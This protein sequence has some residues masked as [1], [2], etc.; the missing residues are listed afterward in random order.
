MNKTLVKRVRDELSRHHGNSEPLAS[1]ITK[2]SRRN[3][4]VKRLAVFIPIERDASN[5]AKKLDRKTPPDLLDDIG[6]K[7]NHGSRSPINDDTS[8]LGLQNDSHDQLS[9]VKEWKHLY[10]NEST[11][12]PRPRRKHAK[13]SPS[14]KPSPKEPSDSTAKENQSQTPSPKDQRSRQVSG[15]GHPSRG[16]E[17]LE[18]AETLLKLD[19]DAANAYPDRLK[20]PAPATLA[21]ANRRAAISDS[22]LNLNE[23]AVAFKLRL[24][25]RTFDDSS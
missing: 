21:D 19:E 9:N 1:F 11:V 3:I 16:K 12:A 25:P 24:Y 4:L 10:E 22:D 18:A 13:K 8:P 7:P 17:E 15:G 20:G 6:V 5:A 23:I 14:P 2:E